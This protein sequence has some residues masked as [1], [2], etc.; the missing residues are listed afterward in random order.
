MPADVIEQLRM[1]GGVLDAHAMPV[2]LGDLRRPDTAILAAESADVIHPD[3]VGE[4]EPTHRWTRRVLAFVA[5]LVVV[6]GLAFV[7]REDDGVTGPA[8]GD[9]AAST[10]TSPQPSTSLTAGELAALDVP[11]DSTLRVTKE[12]PGTGKIWV[13]DTADRAQVC[14]GVKFDDGVSSGGCTEAGLVGTGD[15][16]AYVQHSHSRS[17]P[18]F[19]H[20]ITATDIG[21]SVTVNGQ[22][23]EPDAD[24]IWFAL[25]PLDTTEFTITTNEGSTVVPLVHPETTPTVVLPP[26]SLPSA[27]TTLPVAD[28]APIAIGDSVMLGAQPQLESEGFVVDAAEARQASDVGERVQQLRTEGRL[29]NIVVIHIGTNG[30]VTNDDLAAIM[31]NLPPDE[32]ASVWFLTDRADRPWIAP[33]NQRIM[34][35]PR[36]YPNVQVGYWHAMADTMADGL[37]SDGVH[38]KTDESRQFY[39]DLIGTWTGIAP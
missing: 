20:G 33:N 35:L 22:T 28:R 6:V 19:L 34:A 15:Y 39:A 3:H 16:W 21:F 13:Y 8:T 2:T 14:V 23:I 10:S 18:A 5:V 26:E 9:D 17:V 32:V 29:G 27:T 7:G 31:A 12:I 1:L 37:A 36:S 11:A 25:V 24:G 30:E 38:L 4:E